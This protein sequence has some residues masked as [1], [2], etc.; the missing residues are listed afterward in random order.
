MPN[1]NLMCPHCLEDLGLRD[2][3]TSC[4]INP[5]H[6]KA[7][8]LRAL[9]GGDRCAES[10]CNGHY[11][12]LTCGKCGKYLPDGFKE[13]AGSI[14]VAIVAPSG[15]GKTCFITVMMEELNRMVSRLKLIPRGIGGV[16]TFNKNRDLLYYDHRTPEPTPPGLVT[17]ML[18]QLKDN[19]NSSRSSI[20]VY[21][22]TIFD[23]AG[24]DLDKDELD[25]VISRY[26]AKAELIFLL[27]DPTQIP[28]I[29]MDAERYRLAGGT[30]QRRNA[31]NVV[32]PLVNYIRRQ[33]HTK[34]GQKIRQPVAVVFTKMDSVMDQFEGMQVLQP[35]SHIQKRKFVQ[36]E[37]AIIHEEIKGWLSAHGEDMLTE[38]LDSEFAQWRYFG[39]SPFGVMPQ[40]NMRLN[41]IQP[42][43]VLDPL[44]WALSLEKVVDVG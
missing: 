5:S 17:P 43:R 12:R 26:L 2:I 10:G 40:A 9:F 28:S 22:M 15:A 4:D 25:P 3:H 23:G 19:S 29:R 7:G 34:V 16:E 13:F 39:V 14:R 27:L 24:E 41:D 33:T 36:G 20:P 37:A 6:I 38:R 1:G 31:L 42:L 44:M 35:S 21:S 8:G 30:A 32:D 11:T 18:W